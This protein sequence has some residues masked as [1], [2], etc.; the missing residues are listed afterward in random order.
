MEWGLVS[1]SSQR[2]YNDKKTDEKIH[3]A[4]AQISYTFLI[5]A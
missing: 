2:V 4:D 3:V 1:N 5:H